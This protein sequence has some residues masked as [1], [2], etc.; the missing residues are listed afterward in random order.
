M[1]FLAKTDHIV[2]KVFNVFFRLYL[3]HF[4][5][6]YF[7]KFMYR[8]LNPLL[9]RFAVLKNNLGFFGLDN[10]TVTSTFL[11]R[12]IARKLELRFKLKELFGPITKDLRYI[13]KHKRLLRGYKLQ[14]I[15]RITR[16]DRLKTS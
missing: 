11:S 4:R 2:T 15:G 9:D 13:S 12:Y 16:R 3:V 7:F 6:S 1:S 5:Q 14:F 10:D 8:L